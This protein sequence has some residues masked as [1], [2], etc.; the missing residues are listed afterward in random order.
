MFRIS[1]VGGVW[2]LGILNGAIF[3]GAFL[4]AALA[5]TPAQRGDYL[6]NTIMACGNCHSPR[7]ANGKT[8]AE[9]AF[10]GGLT[11]NTPA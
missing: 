11:F 1:I 9:N 7:D 2:L 5:E 4:S 10:S 3:N 8:I 6:V